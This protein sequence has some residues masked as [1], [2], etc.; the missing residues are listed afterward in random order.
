MRIQRGSKVAF[1]G[2][3]GSGKSTMLKIIAGELIAET[4]MVTAGEAVLTRQFPHMFSISVRDNVSMGRTLNDIDRIY[5][6]LCLKSVIEGL[7][8]GDETVLS[9]NGGNLSGGQRQRIAIARAA[10]ADGGLYLFDESF[11][12]LDA[13][14]AKTVI[15]N[16]L[17]IKKDSTII[18]VIHQNELAGFFD[19][20]YEF[21]DGKAEKRR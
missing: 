2:E 4:G 16:L 19:E 17:E 14:T 1:V 6:K 10:A 21:S 8:E 11:S 5:E 15:R 9:E 20:V 12:A 7:P 18:A 3:S 13:E